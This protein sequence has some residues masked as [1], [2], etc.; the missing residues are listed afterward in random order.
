MPD[1]SRDWRLV[2]ASLTIAV[3]AEFKGLSL[4]WGVSRLGVTQGKA[5]VPMAAVALGG[6]IRSMHFVAMLGLQ[7][8]IFLFYD[9]LTKPVSAWVA[10]RMTGLTLLIPHVRP[11]T[12]RRMTLAGAMLGAGIA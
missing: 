4:T 2:L 8:P 10:I 9:A 5:A 7:L 12:A 1:F 11:R 3:M 6:G